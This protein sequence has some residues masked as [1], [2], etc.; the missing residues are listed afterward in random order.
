[1]STVEHMQNPH[2]RRM[3]ELLRKLSDEGSRRFTL[4][5]LHDMLYSLGPEELR[6]AV[7]AAPPSSLPLEV[8]NYVAAMVEYACA[9]SGV[10]APSW[11]GLIEPLVT[12]V[13]GS[14]LESLR[15]HLL[16]HSPPPFRRRNIFIDTSIGGRV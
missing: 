3:G 15:L 1:M 13:F 11:A 16:T 10:E 12:P 4:A 2:E 14:H 5:E 6:C 8:S 7:T 9:K